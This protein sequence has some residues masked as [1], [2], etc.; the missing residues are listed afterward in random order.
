MGM[1]C[2]YRRKKKLTDGK[3]IEVGP[4]W[5][6]WYRNGTPFSES[7]HTES[8]PE[9]QR[10]LNKRMGDVARGVPVTSKVG[11]VKFDELIENLCNEYR[12]NGRGSR[13][14]LSTAKS[15][16]CPSSVDGEPHLSLRRILT[17]TL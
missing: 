16:C 8:K 7:T 4:Y 13:T 6:K 1:G 12:A 9:A 17:A 2:L 10:E 11:R 15:T 5:I 3:M 14:W